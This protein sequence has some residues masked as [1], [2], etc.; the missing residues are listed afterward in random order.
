MLRR[1]RWRQR[2]LPRLRRVTLLL[3]QCK[4]GVLLPVL[5]VKAVLARLSWLAAVIELR[6]S[7]SPKAVGGVAGRAVSEAPRGRSQRLQR[8]PPLLPRQELW[9]E[10]LGGA[11]N[12]RLASHVARWPWRSSKLVWLGRSDQCGCR[13]RS[14]SR[15][16]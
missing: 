16:S 7:L 9:L 12:A 15:S 10:R 14:R 13:R 6:L 1:L 2:L 5:L 11:A 3:Q 8:R 4:A